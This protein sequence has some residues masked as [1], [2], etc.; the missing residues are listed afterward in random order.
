MLLRDNQMEVWKHTNTISR[1][2]TGAQ[3]TQISLNN[4]DGF[5]ASVGLYK[6]TFVVGAPKDDDEG[7]NKG[8]VYVFEKDS[9][10]RWAEVN[11]LIGS[12]CYPPR[13]RNGACLSYPATPVTVCT[14]AVYKDRWILKNKISENSGGSGETDISLLGLG[15][16]S[17]FGHSLG[18]CDDLLMVGE[19][20]E[21]GQGLYKGAAYIFKIS[22]DEFNLS[23]TISDGYPDN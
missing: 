18:I 9:S 10:D 7:T 15:V 12:T 23:E 1:S 4:Y 6:D 8:A 11:S 19:S 5:G 16:G 13:T 20:N 3:D 2:A 22:G 17:S 14:S 21:G